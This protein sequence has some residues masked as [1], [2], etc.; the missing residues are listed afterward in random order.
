MA[1]D[2]LEQALH[3]RQIGNAL[4]HHSDR[5]V[6]CL[7]NRYS[8]RLT[9]ISEQASVGNTEDSCATTETINRMFTS[10][11]IQTRDPWRSLDAV[12]YTTLEW[13]DWFDTRQLFEPIGHVPPPEFEA[14]SH[15]WKL[16]PAIAAG[17]TP[18]A[19]R[20][21]RGGSRPVGRD[22]PPLRKS[23]RSSDPMIPRTPPP[24]DLNRTIALR[25]EICLGSLRAKAAD[26]LKSRG[27]PHPAFRTA[28]AS[29]AYREL[30]CA[31]STPF[32]GLTLYSTTPCAGTIALI[33][34]PCRP[35]LP[36][37]KLV[38]A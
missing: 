13:V 29:C 27:G 9:A 36:V 35:L 31:R 1:A 38:A 5:G 12:E 11:V 23:Q 2:V 21:F 3:A 19:P 26:G 4:I 22:R 16:G 24:G 20:N 6:Q 18:G 28:Q 30:L 10:E 17:P 25:A 7:S 37:H 34:A 15:S 14:E 33:V 32:P 8:A